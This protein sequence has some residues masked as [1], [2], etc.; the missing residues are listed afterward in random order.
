MGVHRLLRVK[1]PP[2]G[3]VDITH[4]VEKFV[5]DARLVH[6]FVPHTT[7]ALLLNEN[8]PGLLEDIGELFERLVPQEGTYL[9]NKIDNN[10]HAHLRSILLTPSLL[11]PAEN[12]RLLLGTWQRIFLAEWDG[13][14]E[15]RVIITFIR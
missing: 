9:H 7:A 5:S 8:E 13:P 2:R 14:R 10:A 11:I 6:I 15:R 3:L 4:E 12:G 1:T